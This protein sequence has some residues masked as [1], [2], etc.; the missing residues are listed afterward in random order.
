MAGWD[1]FGVESWD[2]LEGEMGEAEGRKG[3]EGYWEH[4]EGAVARERARGGL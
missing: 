1:S 4:L 3:K 2:S